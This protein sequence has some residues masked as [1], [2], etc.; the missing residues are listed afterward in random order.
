[1]PSETRSV[2]LYEPQVEALE[3]IEE[4]HGVAKSEAMRRVITDGLEYRQR[5]QQQTFS[6]ILEK[7]G[8]ASLAVSLAGLALNSTT[9]AGIVAGIAAVLFVVSAVARWRGGR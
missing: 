5:R 4:K 9:P 2:H 8:W 6:E 1:M 3:E 7:F